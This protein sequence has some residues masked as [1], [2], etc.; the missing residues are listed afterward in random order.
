[1]DLISI[2]LPY[3]PKVDQT[4]AAALPEWCVFKARQNILHGT[5]FFDLF[6]A[7]QIVDN[8]VFFFHNISDFVYI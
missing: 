7:A 8:V 3:K 2:L 6:T 5:S 1:M 4:S